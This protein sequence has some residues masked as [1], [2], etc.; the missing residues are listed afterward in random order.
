M[1]H[2]QNPLEYTVQDVYGDEIHIEEEQ[3]QAGGMLTSQ[4]QEGP[5]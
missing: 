3:G 5:H 2:R 1:Y 4:P